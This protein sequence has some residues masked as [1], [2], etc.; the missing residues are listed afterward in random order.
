MTADAMISV[1]DKCFNIGMN[2]FLTKPIDPDNL[3]T[4]MLKWLTPNLDSKQDSINR[5]TDKLDIHNELEGIDLKQGLSVVVGNER[6]YIKLLT[7]FNQN[8]QNFIPQFISTCNEDISEG[9]REL[10][11]FKGVAGNIG[12]IE[13]FNLSSKYENLLDDG[14]IPNKENMNE[15]KIELMKVLN[16][17]SNYVEK[18]SSNAPKLHSPFDFNLK[19]N[20]L[21]NLLS[22]SDPN[23]VNLIDEIIDS[24]NYSTYE[25]EFKLIQKYIS[26]YEFEKGLSELKK[27]K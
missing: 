18:H 4:T 19:M 26:E 8:Y 1:R 21:E 13:L 20:E 17:T 22:I 14:F 27:L 2:D 10:H 12:A 23:S 25:K 9:K 6:L 16:S 7:K 24:A 5:Q 3:F 11:T 15:F